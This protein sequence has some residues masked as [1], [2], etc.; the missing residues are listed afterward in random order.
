MTLSCPFQMVSP[1]FASKI[2]RRIATAA[3]ISVVALELSVHGADVVPVRV[4]VWDEQQPAQK[5]A[6]TNFLGNQIAGY[7]MSRPGLAVKSVRLDDSEQGLSKANLDSC[8]VLVWWGHVRQ[9]E[10]APESGRE[11]VRRIKSG[12]LSLITLHS[13]HWSTPFVE[14]MNER[15]RE[16]ALKMLLP[17]ERQTTVMVE[18]NLYSNRYMA[19]KYDDRRTPSALFRKQ[20][21]GQI[22]VTLTLPNC[23]FP[24]FRA[25][26][27]PSHVFTLMPDH[28]I[29]RG[30]P[31]RFTIPQTE[32]YDEPFHVPP[33]DAMIFEER[34][35]TGEWFRSGSLWQLG[36]GK[37][38]YFRPGHE[39][40]PVY[41]E[42]T[43]L[44]IIENTVRWLGSRPTK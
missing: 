6:Y 23:C 11:I 32:M 8:D 39:T 13:A 5:Q 12:Q 35:E 24:A 20:P 19:P 41:H 33:P 31:R 10:I 1:G 37:V 36:Q 27:K 21:D 4:V 34:W 3:L 44:R 2:L 16:D 43:V 40:Y 14:A 15:A 30:I 22:Q 9:K 26:G 38:F 29:A 17:D 25:D 18:T 28:P 42:A 7:L